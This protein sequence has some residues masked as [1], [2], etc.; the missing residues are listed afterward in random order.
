MQV[1]MFPVRVLFS[2]FPRIVRD[3]ARGLGKEINLV[4]EGEGTEID[5]SV[6]DKIRDP[7]VHLMRNAVDHGVELPE[8]R[9]D[10]GKPAQAT[11]KLTA[12]HE[13]GQIVITI[14]DDGKGVDP[15]VVREA[16]VRKGLRS[17]EAVERLR[18]GGARADL[19]ARALD[20]EDDN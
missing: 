4:V 6:I 14:G 10:A 11:I 7:L 5:R 13:Q 19:R 2:K 17:Q 16:A 12:R 1:R 20:C 3:L 18:P 9:A 15:D 8:V